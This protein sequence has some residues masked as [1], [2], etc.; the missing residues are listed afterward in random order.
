MA[1]DPLFNSYNIQTYLSY[2][3]VQT[4]NS[5]SCSPELGSPLDIIKQLTL[6]QVKNSLEEL[7]SLLFPRKKEI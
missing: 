6:N 7:S 5:V 1:C 4:A 2:L 3:C